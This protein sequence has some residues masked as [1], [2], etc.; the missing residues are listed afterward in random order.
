M[1][2]YAMNTSTGFHP[3]DHET[4]YRSDDGGRTW[5]HQ[6][7]GILAGD[8]MKPDIGLPS[9]PKRKYGTSSPHL[10]LANI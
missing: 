7:T 4:V 5:L 10:V 9:H 6:K 1:T 2:V 8:L 3:P